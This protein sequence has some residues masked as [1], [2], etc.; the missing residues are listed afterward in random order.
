MLQRGDGVSGRPPKPPVRAQPWCPCPCSCLR[1]QLSRAPKPRGHRQPGHGPHHLGAGRP[2]KPPVRA[3]HW[4]PCPCF[5]LLPQLSSAPKTPGGGGG[6]VGDDP[7]NHLIAP[8][9]AGAGPSPAHSPNS[10]GAR[11]HGGPAT[12]GTGPTTTSG[13][14]D[15]QNHLA[16]PCCVGGGL[17]FAH[18]HHSLGA[19]NR[20]RPATSGDGDDVR[21]AMVMMFAGHGC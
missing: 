10:R 1:P 18:A 8:C 20:W 19:R 11:K 5:C 13:G 7:Q 17:T 14:G 4:C 12:P 16:T 6:G 9:R 21:W 15:P 3:L 2:L